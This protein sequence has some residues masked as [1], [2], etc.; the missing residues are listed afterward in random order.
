MKAKII[1]FVCTMLLTATAAMAQ[2]NFSM[3][4]TIKN[5]EGQTINLMYDFGPNPTTVSTTVKN[6]KF[7]FNG[8]LDKP[9]QKAVIYI[10]SLQ[11]RNNKYVRFALEPGNLTTDID[12]N[13]FKTATVHGGKTQEES[14]AFEASLSEINK[15]S[16][17]LE[18]AYYKANTEEERNAIKEKMEPLSTQLREARLHFI[19][20]HPDSYLSPEFLRFFMSRM[21]FEELKSV[22][23]NFT[24]NVKKHGDCAEIVKEINTLE[25]VQPGRQAPDFTANDINGKPF[26]MSSLRGKVVIIDFWASW[27]V[28]CRKSNPHMKSLYD[29]YHDKGLEM[30]YVSDDDSKEDAWRKAVE[31]DG[32]VGDGFHHVLR[33]LKWDR[34]KGI[35]GIDHTN[36]IS[37]KYAIHF[38]PT[39]YLIDRK[40]NIVCKIDEGEDEKLDQLLENLMK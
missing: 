23:D 16:E 1:S 15:Q 13:N 4:G 39:K 22:Y 27:C 28:P 2:G 38:L 20:T 40:G 29:K 30:V 19:K 6:G 5:A 3:K 26:T 37:D 31:K 8:T 36:D 9:Y 7:Q 14:N 34:S 32:L 21:S 17:E 18:D 35:D 10:G 33:G 12:G 25:R 11:D 24:D